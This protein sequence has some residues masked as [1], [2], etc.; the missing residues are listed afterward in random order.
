MAD[1]VNPPPI[2]KLLDYPASIGLALAVVFTT[3]LLFVAGKFDATGGTLTISL[4]VVI[5]F[6]SL[7]T[8]CAFFTVPSDEITS[9]A[10]G[11]LVAAFG[12]VVAHWLGRN[13]KDPP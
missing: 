9:G 10:I 8:F 12:A 13:R 11:G 5:G 3:I 1:I 2:P 4:L 6:L 7:V